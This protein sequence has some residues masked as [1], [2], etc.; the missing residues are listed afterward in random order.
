MG[1]GTSVATETQGKS[2]ETDEAVKTTTPALTMKAAVLIQRWYRRYIARLEMRRRYTWNIFQSIEYAGEQDQLQLS[3]FFSFMLD[4]FTQL[5]GNGPDLI[6]QLLDPLVDP[7]LDRETC[8]NQIHVPESYTGPRLSFPLSVSDTS[9]LLS[10]FKEQ[11][12]LHARYALQLL[13]ET[14]KLLKQMPNI[15]HLSTSYIKD[16]TI[17]GDLHGR[18]DDLLLIFYKNGLPS[19]DTPYVF[20]GDFVDR[21]KKSMEV[22]ILLFA[23]LLL[24]PDSM[25]LN[26]G[27]HEDHIMNLRYGFTKEVMQKYKTHGHEMLKLFQDIFSLLPVATVID[28]KILIVHGGI[29]DQTD[30]D[31]LSSIERHKVKSALRFPRHSVGQLDI[32]QSCRQAKRTRSTDASRP[33]SSRSQSKNQGTPSLRN[34]R[35]GLSRKDS[36]A[37][38][39]SSSSSS[40][41]SSLCS[42]RTPSCLSPRP[43]PSS[44]GMPYTINVLQV[45]FL[46]S[47]SSVPAPSPAQHER[48]WKQIVD[49]LWSDPKT[50]E[51]CSPNTFRGGGCYFGPDV[52][53]RLL[54]RH[55]LQLLIRS[56]ECKQEGYELCHG[57][58]V[59]TIFS[60]SNYYEEGSNR[61]AYVKLGREL[62]PR[63]YQY[64]VSRSTRKLTLTQRVRAAEGSAL[65]ALKE[66]LFAHRCELMAGFLQCDQN[67]TGSVSVSEWAQV[68]ESVLRLDLPWR[69]LRPHLTRLAPD[70]SVDY[71]SCFEDMG[72]GNPLPQVAPNLAETLFRYRTDIEIIFN[73]IDK[74]HSGLISAEEFRHTWRLFSAHLGVDINDRAIDDLARSIDFNKD[75]SIDFTE[76]LEAF[77]VVHKL[78]SKDQHLSGKMDGEKC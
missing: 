72:P 19:A 70:G 77:R 64:Q 40:S 69:T 15:I 73:I 31:F 3:S 51:G 6:S 62:V 30:L 42:P 56:H 41:S 16:I 47:L 7:W 63:F 37:S 24:Y 44:P 11:Q 26:R 10:A 43:C 65:R 57:G 66:K 52:T 17:C 12:T 9:A 25:H 45:P 60:A 55:G 61:G 68:L 59:I 33:S 5:N 23:Y 36:A 74:D 4:N 46:D 76:F 71:P 54:L 13:Y 53:Q 67:N 14:K 20:N 18:L 58:Q 27:N 28:G 78:D 75:G 1:C 49:I 32:G 39:S 48:E 50:Q 2:M 29:S 34:R 8:Y 35:C 22:V 38:N 21:G